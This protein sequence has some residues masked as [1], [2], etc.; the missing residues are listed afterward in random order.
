MKRCDKEFPVLDKCGNAWWSKVKY[1]CATA[2]QREE[3]TTRLGEV[4]TAWRGDARR[5]C[6]W[7]GMVRY[8]EV[9]H[10]KDFSV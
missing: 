8:G 9:M 1:G 6:V 3:W 7:L 2:M 5:G 10:G 4:N